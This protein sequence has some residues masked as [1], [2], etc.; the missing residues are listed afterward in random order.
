MNK[1]IKPVFT[2]IGHRYDSSLGRYTSATTR[3]H[4]FEP[5]EDW[6]AIAQKYLDNRTYSEIIVDLMTK[7]RKSRDQILA[8]IDGRELNVK[9][10]Q[11]IWKVY[12]D[13]ACAKG[14]K[15]HARREHKDLSTPIHEIRGMTIPIGVNPKPVTDYYKDLPDGLYPELL[16]WDNETMTSGTADLVTIK[17]IDGIRWVWVDDYKT[18]K[19]IKDYNY[20]NQ[21]TGAKVVNKY[22]LAP[23]N[24]LCSCSYWKYQIQLNMYGYMLTKFGFTFAGGDIIHTEDGDKRYELMNLQEQ[25]HRAFESWK[26][27]KN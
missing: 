22:L 13:E 12:S 15:E 8:M 27:E 6:E 11:H 16:L 7:Q 14:S 17:T 9:T 5:E 1:Y 19:E 25:V 10:I 21:H 3:I 4:S 23:F 20:I 2:E 18:N 24:N 26:I